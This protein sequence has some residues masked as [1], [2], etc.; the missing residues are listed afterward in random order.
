MIQLYFL[1]FPR[2]DGLIKS[3]TFVPLM[4]GDCADNAWQSLR[5]KTVYEECKQVMN[6]QKRDIDD[7]DDKALRTVRITAILLTVGAS[8]VE[9]IGLD[10]INRTTATISVASFFLS[11]IFGVM[12]YN[13]SDELVGPK[14]SYLK[15]L[16][17]NDTTE[18]WDDDYLYQLE[19]WVD[20]NQE[21]V[22]FNGYLL[23]SCQIFFILGVGTGVS[24][25]VGLSNRSVL[26]GGGIVLVI[27]VA[28]TYSISQIVERP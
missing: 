2:T 25:L 24:A 19:H 3:S 4:D 8:G 22:E 11:L 9:V 27:V 6:A 12:V 18:Q 26:A 28:L 17:T 14:A 5:K 13:E 20:S 7:L 23:M 21:I 1:K 16:R 10:S 15:K